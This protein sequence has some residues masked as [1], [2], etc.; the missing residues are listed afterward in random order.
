MKIAKAFLFFWLAFSAASARGGDYAEQVAHL[1][2]PAVLERVIKAGASA[3]ADLTTAL[4]GPRPDLAVQALGKMK[5]KQAVPELSKLLTAKD[6]ELR[7]A[8]AWAIGECGSAESAAG[9]IALMNDPY[10]RVRSSAAAALGALR[11]P[12]A[13]A[14]LRRSLQDANSDV[15]M[16]AV[17]TIRANKR[18]DLFSLLLP[19][20]QF[21]IEKTILKKEGQE[22]REVDTVVW[23]EPSAQV[24]LAAI[25]TLS[26]LKAADAIP[27]LIGALEREESFNRLTIIRAI[28][29][30][31]PGAAGTCLGRIVPMPY[32]KETFARHMPILINNG[33]LAVIAGRLGDGRCV[34]AL[35][36]T[37]K[38]PREKLG[39]DKDL[40][41]LYIHSVELL[42]K[43]K[44]DRAGRPLAE[45]LKETRVR[46]LSEAIQAAIESIG[47]PAARPLARNM[48]DWSLAP[49]FLKLLRQPDL[50]TP[51]AREGIL[52]FLGHES[53][54]VRLAATETLGM[55][56]MDGILDEY[57][58]PLLDAM[59]LDP[60][61]EV[62]ATCKRWQEKLA[63][64]QGNE[65]SP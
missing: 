54:D 49:V 42:G 28:E 64:K 9:L 30:M 12:D 61:K 18:S 40:T 57:D 19:C 63:K 52:K 23:T 65:V 14:A 22:A 24:R 25:S 4:N 31:G 32:E 6:G 53:D 56:L 26:D 60:N 47:R 38:L 8:A 62:R 59:Y 48:D 17:Q 34:T 51:V 43:Y 37:L 58:Q 35:L 5:L 45:L 10:A 27:A 55:Y 16:A 21:R 33:T 44:C 41:E 7:A 3:L 39:Q 36:E 1:D 15:R 50:R 2:D 29:G 13:D 20:L 46:Q 11:T